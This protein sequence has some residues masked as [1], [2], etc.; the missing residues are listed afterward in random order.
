MGDRVWVVARSLSQLLWLLW[1]AI[2]ELSMFTLKIPE[3][4]CVVHEH[5]VGT[6]HVGE[7][8]WGCHYTQ[9]HEHTLLA[10]DN[11]DAICS[12]WVLL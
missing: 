12:S 6:D 8:H 10:A 1:W 4:L 5:T 11:G 9:R 3:I 7:S 2:V